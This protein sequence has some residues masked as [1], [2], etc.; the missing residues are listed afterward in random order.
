MKTFILT[1][2]FFCATFSFSQQW[3]DQVYDIDTIQDEVYGNALNFNNS[4]VDLNL[5]IYLPKCQD[6]STKRPLMMV[7]HG[8][9]F[10]TG[11]YKDGS[12][13]DICAQFAR[14]GYVAV[15]VQ[16]RLGYVCND[17]NHVCNFANYPCLFAT[18][19]M[20]WVRAYYRGIQDVKGAVRYMV[21]RKDQFHIDEQNVFLC[22][23]SAGAFLAMGAT[24]MDDASERPAATFALP[25]ANQPFA[26]AQAECSH[27]S[28][29]VFSGT[30]ARPDLG[31]IDGAIEPMI[32]PYTIRGVGNIFGGMFTNLLTTSNAAV[33][34]ALYSFHRACDPIVPWNSKKVYFGLS[35]CFANGYGCFGIINT[36][37]VHGSKTIDDWNTNQNLGYDI[38]TELL[39]PPFPYE[40]A[41]F[42]P[43]NCADQVVNGNACHAYDNKQTRMLNMATFFATKIVNP[44]TCV[45][46]NSLISLDNEGLTVY[47]N[48]T[49]NILHVKSHQT[50]EKIRLLDL[51]G[52]E[53]FVFSV[54]GTTFQHDLTKMASGVY[55]VECSF[56]NG[57]TQT[58]VI[59]R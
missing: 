45:P 15:S 26:N 41:G 14:R 20:E 38:S 13:Q 4:P 32:Y 8:G 58:V 19:T 2:L 35:W 24:Y 44:E 54:N 22:G 53:L 33:K 25:N 52:K 40:Y 7:V 50:M 43:Y 1:S 51:T 27:N 23:E 12:V 3:I 55:V 30:V 29:E 57:R 46:Y 5:D 49:E 36:P 21:N 10:I 28:G 59:R 9:G 39:T 47:P 18:D 11:S 34:P 48:P 56:E 31:G 17:T 42:Q 16:Y 6:T 37:M